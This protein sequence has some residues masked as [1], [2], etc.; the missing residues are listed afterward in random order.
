MKIVI[1]CD[2]AGG[3]IDGV[4]DF[5]TYTGATAGEFHL[6]IEG[7]KNFGAVRSESGGDLPSYGTGG[8]A[9]DLCDAHA[10]NLVVN[11]YKFSFDILDCFNVGDV[12]GDS[13][14]IGGILGSHMYS[15]D[16][17]GHIPADV[18]TVNIKNCVNAGDRKSVV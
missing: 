15:A 7:C 13:R 1:G 4:K 5:N 6:L 8:I 14:H 18:V 10:A 2:H 12:S 16:G 9:G 11:R 17:G 3:I